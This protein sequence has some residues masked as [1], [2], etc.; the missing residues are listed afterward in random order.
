MNQHYFVSFNKFQPIKC[1]WWC[2]V[3]AHLNKTKFKLDRLKETYKNGEIP[4]LIH[5]TLISKSTLAQ[6]TNVDGRKQP[7]D[8]Y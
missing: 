3:I 7:M 2:D 4:S 1:I 8:L 6:S 5:H